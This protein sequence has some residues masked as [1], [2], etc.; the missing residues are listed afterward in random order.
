MMWLPAEM[1]TLAPLSCIHVLV[2]MAMHWC[3][4]SRSA[5]VGSREANPAGEP[6]LSRLGG[7]ESK[8]KDKVSSDEGKM[9]CSVSASLGSVVLFTCRNVPATYDTENS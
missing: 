7:S 1:F 9:R 2:F 8:P 5:S 3:A 6:S 4:R